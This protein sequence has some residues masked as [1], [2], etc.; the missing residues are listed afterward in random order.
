[1]S[2]CWLALIIYGGT[3]GTAQGELKLNLLAFG[4][5]ALVGLLICYFVTGSFAWPK[6]VR[7]SNVLTDLTTKEMTTTDFKPTN[8]A[9]EEFLANIERSKRIISSELETSRKAIEAQWKNQFNDDLQRVKKLEELVKKSKVI[10]SSLFIARETFH[11]HSWINN[12]KGKWNFPNWIAERILPTDAKK[13]EPITLE[14]FA[15]IISKNIEQEFSLETAFAFKDGIDEISQY[16]YSTS[17]FTGGKSGRLLI[18]VNKELVLDAYISH[19]I[20]DE[21]DQWHFRYSE[22]YFVKIGN[23]ISS[24]VNLEEEFIGHS[25]LEK[26]TRELTAQEH[27]ISNFT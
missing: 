9:E 20:E 18:K 23:W 22:I 5:P 8:S 3:L 2:S 11:W 4:W 1:M 7:D 15:S 21:Y 6:D 16:I 17:S 14:S 19:D 13:D 12:Q 25:K 10:E 27:K 26:T 24:I